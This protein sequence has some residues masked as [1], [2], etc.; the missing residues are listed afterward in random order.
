MFLIVCQN[1]G[2]GSS[3]I[4]DQVRVVFRELLTGYLSWLSIPLLGPGLCVGMIRSWR[5]G[6]RWRCVEGVG[7][8]G[9][10]GD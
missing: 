7:W 4:H 3:I 2:S 6:R 9:W 5:L 1:R 10:G 8:V